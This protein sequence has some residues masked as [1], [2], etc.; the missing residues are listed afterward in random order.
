MT[1]QE[2]T[3]GEERLFFESMPR[4]CERAEQVIKSFLKSREGFS[5]GGK[6]PGGMVWGGQSRRR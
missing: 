4:P 3:G 5:S 1:S 2:T 6:G